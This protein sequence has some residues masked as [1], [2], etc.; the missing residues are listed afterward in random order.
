MRF[1]F[2]HVLL[3]LVTRQAGR[4]HAVETAANMW[5]QLN[6]A[7]IVLAAVAD[8]AASGQQVSDDGS[9]LILPAPKQ[10]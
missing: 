9:L 3:A 8:G 1:N 6:P 7:L 4:N 10:A 2:E 5:R